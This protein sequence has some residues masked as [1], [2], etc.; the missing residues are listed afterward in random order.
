MRLL[1]A[2]A[3]AA[4]AWT[5]DVARFGT[6]VAIPDGFRGQIYFLK[7]GANQLP[8][9]SKLKPKGTIYTTSIN[10]PAQQFDQGFP[11]VSKRFE[12]FAIDY[13]ARFWVRTPGIHRFILTSDDGSR[14]WIDG[15][16]VVD[17]DGVHP[18]QD[19]YGDIEL[20]GGLHRIEVGYFQ[21]PRF[22]VAL[23]L[24]VMPPG[25]RWRIFNVDEFKPPADT[26][27][28]PDAPAQVEKKRK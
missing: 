7:D 24:K 10:V 15:R 21:G 3:I 23:V 27:I 11:G 14:L 9:F 12:W 4:A 1:A 28:P 6:T 18:P 8:N 26:E 16:L 25:E 17:N 19:R 22:G 2:L 13:T 20:A 5:Q